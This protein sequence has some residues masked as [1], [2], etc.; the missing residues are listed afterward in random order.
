MHTLEE[1]RKAAPEGFTFHLLPGKGQ[2]KYYLEGKGCRLG[3]LFEDTL[4]VYYE[5]LTEEG[6]P[7]PYGP[8]LR[9]KWFPKY[10]LAQLILRGVWEVTEVQPEAVLS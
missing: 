2:Y 8:A 1:F 5:W 3:V 7:V 6:E 9:Y 4:N 10:E